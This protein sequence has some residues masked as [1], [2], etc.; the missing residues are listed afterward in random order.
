MAKLVENPEVATVA[1]ASLVKMISLLVAELVVGTH[2][3]NID[4]VESNVRAKLFASVD[5]VSS[6]ATAA[7]VALAHRLVEPVLRD[8]RARAEARLREEEAEGDANPAEA[9]SALPKVAPSRLN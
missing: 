2:H 1:L 4:L 5:G 9:P 6:E 3:D 8:L 7:G